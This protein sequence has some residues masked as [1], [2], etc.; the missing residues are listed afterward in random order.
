MSIAL[1]LD[2]D[3]TSFGNV[4][5]FTFS[6][7]CSGS[8]RLLLVG[9]ANNNSSVTSTLTATYNGVAM[10]FLLHSVTGSETRSCDFFGLLAPDTGT[11]DVTV[12]K[13]AQTSTEFYAGATSFT[14]VLQSTPIAHD[15]GSGNNTAGTSTSSTTTLVTS[16]DGCWAYL[17]FAKN[18]TTANSNSIILSNV[19]GRGAATSNGPITPI[20]TYTMVINHTSGLNCGFGVIAFRP[21]SFTPGGA[22][23]QTPFLMNFM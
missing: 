5:S 3:F 22:T 16:V 4:S 18:G 6:H 20:G 23:T 7:T 12:T 1:D 9:V 15:I 13:G 10:T 17:V 19:S 21:T 8:E 11:H 14:G 2:T